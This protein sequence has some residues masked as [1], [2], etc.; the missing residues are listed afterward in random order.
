[1]TNM[2]V[3]KNRLE[4]DYVTGDHAGMYSCVGEQQDSGNMKTQNIS[5]IVLGVTGGGG[6]VNDNGNEKCG[7]VSQHSQNFLLYLTLGVYLCFVLA[8]F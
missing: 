8:E 4:I 5:L 3:V 6:K 1:M 2:T 7:T